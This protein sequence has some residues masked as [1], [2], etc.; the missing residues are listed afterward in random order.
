[1]IYQAI[2]ESILME[3]LI[4]A[5]QSL[6]QKDCF[7]YIQLGATV[8]SIIIS[9][10]AVFVA[11]RIPKQIAVQQNQMTKQIADDQNRIALFEKRYKLYIL[12]QNY[13]TCASHIKDITD[14]NDII[15][16]FSIYFLE[17]EEVM[18]RKSGAHMLL[19]LVQTE[20]LLISGIFLFRNYNCEAIKKIINNAIELMNVIYEGDL[21]EIYNKRDEFCENCQAFEDNDLKKLEEELK[22]N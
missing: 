20:D 6:G 19:R 10:I 4:I 18:E 9:A 21:S 14:I 3:D 11:V 5:I 2:E 16:Y 13:L 22:L 7:D 1:M 15:L 12:I 17:P 8:T